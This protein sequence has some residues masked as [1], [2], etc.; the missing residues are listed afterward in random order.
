MK[1]SKT[2]ITFFGLIL[3]GSACAQAPVPA[4]GPGQQQPAAPGT[5]VPPAQPPAAKAPAAEASAPVT[6]EEFV[7]TAAKSGNHEVMA[8]TL[9]TTKATDKKVKAFAAMLV[10]DHTAA[11]KNLA[12]VAAGMKIPLPK[13]DPEGQA[14]Y[15]A[16]GAKTGEEFDTAFLEEMRMGHDKSI[17][18]FESAKGTAKTKSLVNFIDKTLP[19]IKGHADKMAK[20]K[21]G[22]AAADKKPSGTD[23]AKGPAPR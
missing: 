5:P 23:A 10:K 18:L 7:K 19:V 21:S 3:A 20:M 11:N 22:P 9:A 2:L 1:L 17:A 15:D 16:L 6:E 12:A 14:K 13:E 4:R 8:A